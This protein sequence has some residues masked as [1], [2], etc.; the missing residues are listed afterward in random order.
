MYN[1]LMKSS[2]DYSEWEEN[3]GRLYDVSRLAGRISEYTAEA[4]MQR[5]PQAAA[6]ISTRW[7]SS[8]AS[9]PM[10]ASM[11]WVPL[12]ASAR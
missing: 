10:R 6:L 7:Y 9:S 8:R 2:L 5:S 12:A 4:L 1:L 11:W 3:Q